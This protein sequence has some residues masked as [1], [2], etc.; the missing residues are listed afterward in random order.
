MPLLR[1]QRHHLHNGKGRL[2]IANNNDAIVIREK[3]ATATMAKTL[4]I[5]GTITIEMWVMPP[6]QQQAARA[7]TLA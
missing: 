7:T 1:G 4:R 5:D 6:A 3:I 2:C